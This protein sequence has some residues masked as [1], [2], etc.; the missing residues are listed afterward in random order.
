MRA[1]PSCAKR[2]SKE[3]ISH[4]F[5]PGGGQIDEAGV[6]RLRSSRARG[7]QGRAARDRRASYYHSGLGEFILPY[8]AVA[9]RYIAG[10]SHRLFCR[11]H[12]RRRG[13]TCQVGSR[14]ARTI[15]A[16]QSEAMM[17]LDVPAGS[18]LAVGLSSHGHS[19]RT[20]SNCEPI[21]D[22]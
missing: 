9:D 5:W 20:F 16:G 1:P 7:P 6:L 21:A 17:A 11:Q 12:L 13:G 14:G 15:A 4:G 22:V 10:S 3:V 19:E 2:N 8:E 18:R